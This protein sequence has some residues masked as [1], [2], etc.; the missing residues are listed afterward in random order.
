MTSESEP[1]THAEQPGSTS[2]LA[3]QPGTISLKEAA[4]QFGISER[5]VRRRI[6]EGTLQGYKQKVDRGYE[7]RV[8]VGSR[9][10]EQ[11][12]I[13][14]RQN[15]DDTGKVPSRPADAEMPE[16]TAP[17]VVELVRLVEHLQRDNQ[18]MAGQLGFM[19]AKLQESERRA[20]HAEEQVRLLMAPKDEPVEPEPPAEPVRVSWWR[21]LLDG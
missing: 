17:G 15:A 11:P 14:P 4:E 10:A 18:Q 12:G 16:A 8:Y 3:E 5:T 2:A 20:L 13:S 6:D 7:W 19:Q 21:R 9:L 1:G